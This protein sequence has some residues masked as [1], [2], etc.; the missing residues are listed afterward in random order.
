MSTDGRLFPYDFLQQFSLLPRLQSNCSVD[1]L[2]ERQSAREG[3][4]CA[5]LERMI[6][7]GLGIG[8]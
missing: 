2:A 6:P 8:E 5:F 4:L 7:A 3:A 1:I